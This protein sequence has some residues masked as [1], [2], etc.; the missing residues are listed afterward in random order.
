MYNWLRQRCEDRSVAELSIVYT[1]TAVCSF[2]ALLLLWGQ[3]IGLAGGAGGRFPSD[4]EM[5]ILLLVL[6]LLLFLFVWVW[7]CLIRIVRMWGSDRLGTPIFR[8]LQIGFLVMTVFTILPRSE[9]RENLK[10]LPFMILVFDVAIAVMIINFLCLAWFGRCK[11]P[12]HAYWEI[13]SIVIMIIVQVLVF[14]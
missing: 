1:L 5:K 4:L 2:L 14:T 8:M 11:I 9:F 6:L 12:L 10:I 13:G 3:F 7:I